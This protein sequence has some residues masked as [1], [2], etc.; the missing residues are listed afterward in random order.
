MNE[1][2]TNKWVNDYLRNEYKNE[3]KYFKLQQKTK[4]IVIDI[5]QSFIILLIV[6]YV[7][8]K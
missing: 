7:L 4:A 5:M 8:F 2:K 6:F 1:S 3:K